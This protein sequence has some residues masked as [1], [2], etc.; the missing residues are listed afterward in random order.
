MSRIW[1][2]AWRMFNDVK[3]TDLRFLDLE[4]DICSA[5]SSIELLH[6]TC[7]QFPRLVFEVALPGESIF[8]RWLLF[9][10]G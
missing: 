9:S 5:S 8:V 1:V 7:T 6:S 10:E 2:L 3:K 4:E